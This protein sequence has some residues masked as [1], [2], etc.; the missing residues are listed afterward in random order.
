MVLL[1]PCLANYI[2]FGQSRLPSSLERFLW[3]PIAC[4]ESFR[5]RL[6]SSLPGM[7]WWL[8]SLSAVRF[9]G[10]EGKDEV[11]DLEH[12][13]G[14]EAEAMGLQRQL[15]EVGPEVVLGIELNP[16]EAELARVSV[17]I[18]AIQWARRNACL[19]ASRP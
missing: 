4:S 14:L 19:P 9:C 11:K 1:R 6:P 18:G 13:A 12:Q 5:F 8:F 15:P 10:E 7:D 17:W 2:P 3:E 16:Y